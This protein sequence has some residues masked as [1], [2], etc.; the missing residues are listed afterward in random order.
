MKE[1]FAAFLSDPAAPRSETQ[2][3]IMQAAL[4]LFAEHGFSRAT[5]EAIARRAHVTEK[6]LFRHFGNKKHLFAKTVYPAMLRMLEPLAF[7]SL[8]AVLR[9]DYPTL[10]ELLRGIVADRIEF[11]RRHPE[12]L[13]L[14]AQGLLLH[15]D[16][17]EAFSEF[18]TSRFLP[19]NKKMLRRARARGELR[20]L[21]DL[22]VLRSLISL[23][24]GFALY[25]LLFSPGKKRRNDRE[26]ALLVDILLNGISAGRSAPANRQ[27]PR[28]TRK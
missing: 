16:F 24:V 28:H 9:S 3:R 22:A 4:D 14:L 27:R 18:W 12:I 2:Q 8:R 23:T 13:K 11:N 21:P 19:E 1:E 5:T 17:R 15:P 6:T 26:A 7:D 20:D 25:A 10:R